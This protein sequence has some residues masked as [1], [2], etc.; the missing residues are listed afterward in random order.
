MYHNNT[1]LS[2][3]RLFSIPITYVRFCLFSQAG[4]WG[5]AAELLGE[6]RLAGVLDAEVPFASDE[7]SAARDAGRVC[8]LVCWGRARALDA[9]ASDARGQCDALWLLAVRVWVDVD[10]SE[11]VLAWQLVPRAYAFRHRPDPEELIWKD[12]AGAEHRG[13]ALFVGML[14]DNLGDKATRDG[15]VEVFVRLF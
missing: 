15:T 7:R 6:F 13:R 8:R 2:Q 3:S 5:S 10:P 4:P 12:A 11:K 1:G 9:W 14:G